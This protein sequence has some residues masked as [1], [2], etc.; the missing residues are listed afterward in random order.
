MT[1]ILRHLV[2]RLQEQVFVLVPWYV[3]IYK[4][5]TEYVPTADRRLDGILLNPGLL[6]RGA[7]YEQAFEG[8]KH[9]FAL[10]TI[11]NSINTTPHAAARCVAHAQNTTISSPHRSFHLVHV[12]NDLP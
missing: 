4:Y 3:K 10:G 12:L 9:F 1:A 2:P 5:C 6:A 11:S 7:R 8:R